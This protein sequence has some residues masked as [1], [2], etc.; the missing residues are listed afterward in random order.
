MSYKIYWDKYK[1]MQIEKVGKKYI[2]ILDRNNFLLA[3]NE[4]MPSFVLSN[5]K[6]VNYKLPGLIINR[7]PLNNRFNEKDFISYVKR[8]NCMYNTDKFSIQIID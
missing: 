7:V 5:I 4:G 3:I 6:I 2:A 1:I 8:T